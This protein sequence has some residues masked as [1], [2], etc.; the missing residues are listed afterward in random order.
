MVSSKVIDNTTV[1]SN[2]P[3]TSVGGQSPTEVK[4]VTVETALTPVRLPSKFIP[5]AR[6]P[7]GLW[8]NGGSRTTADAVVKGIQALVAKAVNAGRV[9]GIF[10]G[11]AQNELIQV[12]E[13]YSRERKEIPRCEG[14]SRDQQLCLNQAIR[15][16]LDNVA[17]A[18]VEHLDPVAERAF[19]EGVDRSPF[20]ELIHD[21]AAA[22]L[23]ENLKNFS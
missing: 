6:R 7:G 16:A 12:L 18:S 9:A 5:G 14:L 15:T 13:G 17:Y 2:T 3:L 21:N 19:W 20:S 11:P 8:S 4:G 23:V 1:L 10:T 22:A